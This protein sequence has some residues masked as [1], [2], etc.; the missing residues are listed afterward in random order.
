MLIV[1]LNTFQ[2]EFRSKSG[3]ESTFWGPQTLS[4]N[5]ISFYVNF[6]RRHARRAFFISVLTSAPPKVA[7]KYE[8][9]IQLSGGTTDG[10]EIQFFGSPQS[11]NFSPKIPVADGKALALLDESVKNLLIDEDLVVEVKISE[12]Q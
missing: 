3:R 2:E 11:L 12:R 1:I 6:E 5:G 10:E 8:Y 7:K 9:R 4:F